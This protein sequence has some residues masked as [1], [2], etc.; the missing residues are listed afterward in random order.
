[1]Q[2]QQKFNGTF[3]MTN[4]QKNS[5]IFSVQ[6]QRSCDTNDDK[7]EST[8]PS[9]ITTNEQEKS[10]IFSLQPQRSPDPNDD[11]I[12]STRPILQVRKNN[13]TLKCDQEHHDSKKSNDTRAVSDDDVHVGHASMGGSTSLEDNGRERLKRHR[14]EVAGHVW[15]P[16]IWGQEELLKDWIDCS[17]FDKSLMNNNIMSARA[18]LVEERRRANST[19]RLRIENSC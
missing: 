9:F 19:C 17:A 15:I 2:Q 1:M 18:A 4:E 16:D 8:R 5:S 7:I 11:K 10:S 13:I 3:T 12:E 14:V 6:P